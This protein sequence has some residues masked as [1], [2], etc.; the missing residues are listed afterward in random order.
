MQ[1]HHWC[2]RPFVL[3]A[4]P[5]LTSHGISPASLNHQFVEISAIEKVDASD[6]IEIDWYDC[7]IDCSL[8]QRSTKYP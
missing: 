4:I 8:S 7:L 3:G 5:S 2:S 6:M 1:N